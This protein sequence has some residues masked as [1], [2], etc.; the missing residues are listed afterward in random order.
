MRARI[1]AT[2]LLALLPTMPALATETGSAREPGVIERAWSTLQRWGQRISGNAPERESDPVTA[3]QRALNAR[4]Y[5]AGEVDGRM[6][7]KTREAV[8]A[9]Q[10]AQGLEVTG[11]LDERTMARLREG[12]ADERGSASPGTAG[13]RR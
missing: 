6:G 11:R 2:L 3:A 13:T 1:L 5:D 8:R 10:E 7:P 12:R 9:F 4:G